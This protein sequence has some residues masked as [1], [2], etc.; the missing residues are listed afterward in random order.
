MP[1]KCR[2]LQFQLRAEGRKEFKLSFDF[3]NPYLNPTLGIS[4][5][6]L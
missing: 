1:M 6:F 3:D 5:L 2:N 4:A